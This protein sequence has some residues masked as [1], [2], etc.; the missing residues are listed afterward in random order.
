MAPGWLWSGHKAVGL[1]SLRFCRRAF[2]KRG[3]EP[4][5][6]IGNCFPISNTPRKMDHVMGK[7]GMGGLCSRQPHRNPM[8]G[9]L[10]S[11]YE[12]EAQQQPREE[13]SCWRG[14]GEGA[15]PKRCL[16]LPM[17]R[18]CFLFSPPQGR[19]LAATDGAWTSATKHRVHSQPGAAPAP[20]G[21]RKCGKDLG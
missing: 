4:G 7:E 21:D 5:L 16:V 19:E 11:P 8:P 20:T 10:M 2:W 12:K 15:L 18:L 3:S 1:S 17:L 9:G 14:W 13:A 6:G